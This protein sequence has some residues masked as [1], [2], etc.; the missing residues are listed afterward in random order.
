MRIYE[1]PD[2]RVWDV[3]VS[4]GSYGRLHALF[5]ARDGNPVRETPLTAATSLD[6]ERYLLALDAAGLEALF[7]RS[8]EM[9]GD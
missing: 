4:K 9:N 2:G 7:A 5:A 3:L 8:E 6:A 1:D